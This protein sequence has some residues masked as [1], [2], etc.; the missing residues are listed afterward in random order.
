MWKEIRCALFRKKRHF[1]IVRSP[2]LRGMK[3]ENSS[4][5]PLRDISH[6]DEVDD[7]SRLNRISFVITRGALD[8]DGI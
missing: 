4:I 3:I 5:S 8:V 2:R 1:C 7:F 6:D